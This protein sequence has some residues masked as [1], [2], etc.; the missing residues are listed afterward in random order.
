MEK[1]NDRKVN[2][3]SSES[4]YSKPNLVKKKFFFSW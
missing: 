4:F 3:R 1:V 2:D